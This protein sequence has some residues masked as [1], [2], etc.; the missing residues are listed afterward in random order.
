[1]GGGE[2]GG[3]RVERGEMR[4]SGGEEGKGDSLPAHHTSAHFHPP[5]PPTHTHTHTHTPSHSCCY[6]TMIKWS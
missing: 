3:G 2:W 4:K 1:M 5:S 6:S